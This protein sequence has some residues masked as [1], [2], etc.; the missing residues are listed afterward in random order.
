MERR[1]WTF[2]DSRPLPAEV[3]VSVKSWRKH[4]PGYE[5]TILGDRDV[6]DVA[7]STYYQLSPTARS[8]V[9]RCHA[10]ATYGGIWMDATITLRKNLDWV[11]A[12]N[13]VAPLYAFK[14][15][16]ARYV[17]NWFLAV[18]GTRGRRLMSI[19]RDAFY[20]IVRAWPNVAN[21][22]GPACTN[23][24]HYF[25]MYEAWCHI[26]HRLPINIIHTIDARPYMNPRWWVAA[27]RLAKYTSG[28]RSERYR[29]RCAM[30]VVIAAILVAGMVRFYQGK[31]AYRVWNT[32]RPPA[33]KMLQHIP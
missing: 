7:P 31:S 12:G 22:Y 17:E 3:E 1:V 32:G 9:A 16:E 10:L 23:D 19:W 13:P 27:P 26:S 28:G 25:M 6:A 5:I 4:L 29:W 2:W 20:R 33:V 30:R 15:P 8:D 14:L 18:R 11:F 21:F 24:P